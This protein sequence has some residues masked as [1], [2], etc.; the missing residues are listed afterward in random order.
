M[1]KYLIILVL[2]ASQTAFAQFDYG[3]DFSKSGTAGYQFLKIGVGAEQ[4]ALGDAVT[5]TVHDAAAVFWNPAGLGWLENRQVIAHYSNWLVNSKHSAFVLAFPFKSLQL[6]F[7]VVSLNVESFEETT[8]DEPLGT[9]RMVDA[10]NVMA[11][12]AV[13]R[14]FTDR[15]SIGGQVKFVQ[16]KLDDLTFNNVLFDIGTIYFTGFRDLRLAFAFQHFGPDQTFRDQKFK[17]PLLFRVGAADNLVKNENFRVTAAVDLLHPTDNRE[18]VNWGL[19][20]AFLDA[21]A[22]RGGYRMNIDEGNLT[23]GVGLMSP[24][25]AGFQPKIDYAYSSFGDVF[26]A[27]HRFSVALNF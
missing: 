15:L 10:G 18:W 7:S 25:V 21:L 2:I 9:G 12:F 20:L 6:G 8:V 4:I 3:F 24:N 26:G 22:L 11:G 16:E 5:A 19:E 13:T 14:R 17:M 27:V 23:L 1:K